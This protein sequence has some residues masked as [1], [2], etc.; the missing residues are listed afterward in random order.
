MLLT[1]GLY[2]TEARGGIF[3]RFQVW[4][5]DFSPYPLLSGSC[6]LE[7]TGRSWYML[8]NGYMRTPDEGTMPRAHGGLLEAPLASYP[9]PLGAKK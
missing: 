1:L 4:A 3:L 5:P 7:R 8:Q 2:R 6:G 9:D